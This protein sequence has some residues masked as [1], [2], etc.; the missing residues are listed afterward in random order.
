MKLCK[1]LK[2]ARLEKKHIKS[3]RIYHKHYYQIIVSK[4]ELEIQLRKADHNDN[5]LYCLAFGKERL[6]YERRLLLASLKF[7]FIG[8]LFYSVHLRNS[9]GETEYCTAK[10]PIRFYEKMFDGDMDTLDEAED[11]LIRHEVKVITAEKLLR[12]YNAVKTYCIRMLT[13][14]LETYFAGEYRS[15]IDYIANH[16]DINLTFKHKYD[17]MPVLPDEYENDR[18][19]IDYGRPSPILCKPPMWCKIETTHWRNFYVKKKQ[20]PGRK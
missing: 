19:Q 5:L 18:D 13:S 15:I 20:N 6:D 16:E 8:S 3:G 7:Q 1:N 17:D 10:L 4:E 12:K 2:S 14:E 11:W 9:S